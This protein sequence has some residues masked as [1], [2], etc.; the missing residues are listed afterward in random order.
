MKLNPDCIRD[1][2]LTVE[3]LST[4]F[5]VIYFGKGHLV[6]FIRLKDYSEDE[7][8]YHLHQCDLSGFFTK[9]ARTIGG[10][11]SIDD[12]SPKGHEFLANIRKDTVWSDVK[13]VAKKV[14]TTSLSALSQIASSVIT[15]LIKAQFGL[16][17]MPPQIM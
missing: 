3:E 7:V 16:S 1:I 10:S 14:G 15:E 5:N 13:G 4:G 8:L 17:G 2:L 9:A 12:L 11:Y 6:K